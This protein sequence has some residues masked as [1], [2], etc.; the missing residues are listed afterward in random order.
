MLR[1]AFEYPRIQRRVEVA[2]VGVRRRVWRT[3]VRVRDALVLDVRIIGLEAEPVE[4]VGQEIE[5]G[6]V[7]EFEALDLR[8]GCVERDRLQ[9]GTG[10]AVRSAPRRQS[11]GSGSPHGWPGRAEVPLPRFRAPH[12]RDPGAHTTRPAPPAI[13]QNPARVQSP[14]GARRWLHRSSVGPP[15]GGRA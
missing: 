3:Q 1:N 12:A 8:S 10:D 14:S 4:R 13:P 15:D 11:P 5:E 7:G 2:R 9:D 6:A